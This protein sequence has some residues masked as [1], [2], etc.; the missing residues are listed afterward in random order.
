LI[1]ER[2]TLFENIIGNNSV[3]ASLREDITSSHLPPCILLSGDESA[4][5]L[6]VALEIARS[7]NCKQNAKWNCDCPSC[8]KSRSLALPD[9][10][11]IGEKN[12]SYEIKAAGVALLKS[13][14]RGAYYLFLRAIKKLLI[15]FDSN[16]WQTSDT[17]FAKAVAL[18]PDIEETLNEIR[19]KDGEIE[20]KLASFEYKKLENIITSLEKKC[21]KLQDECMYESIPVSVVREAIVWMHLR[22]GERRKILIVEN[23]QKMQEGARNA[24]LKIL[25]EPPEYANFI[26]TTQNKNAIMPTILSRV[27]PYIF[28]RRSEREEEEVLRRVFKYEACK[29][30]N[31][32]KGIGCGQFST[33]Q[34][35]FYDHLPVS[36]TE[37]QKAASKF[38]RFAFSSQKTRVHSFT[39]LKKSL[40]ENDATLG[41]QDENSNR[42]ISKISQELN[43]FKPSVVYKLFLLSIVDILHASIARGDVENMEIEAYKKASEAIDVARGEVEIYNMTCV[44]VLQ[45]LMEELKGIFV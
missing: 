29:D 24:F 14:T 7:L 9:F 26:L 31:R 10:L 34:S 20:N 21:E 2:V 19:A 38:L 36:Y 15:R 28:V 16:L 22:P 30:I 5:K 13:K 18:L 35:F 41:V 3:I 32:V 43:K 1:E 12:C 8:E 11:I 44:S 42:F 39:S 25:E 6:T 27:R 23:A 37:I 4:G 33:L 45:E 17:I 40:V